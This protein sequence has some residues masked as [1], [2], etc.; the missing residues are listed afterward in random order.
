MDK[1]GFGSS[2][3]VSQACDGRG[4]RRRGRML[5][6]G[7]LRYVVLKYI[8]QQPRHGYDLI[9][10][11]QEQSGEVYS[12]S[13]GMIYPMLSMLEDLGY[14][15][16][17]NEGSKKLYYLTSQG[18]DFL[19]QNQELAQAI[20]NRLS[21][22][23]EQGAGRVRARLHALRDAVHERLP[24]AQGDPVLQERMATVLE[25]ALVEIQAL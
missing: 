20:E 16:V 13:P 15:S 4:G 8:G 24:L 10:I 22:L 21:A 9:K 11:L 14:V 12:P 3:A 6:Q 17:A 19:A 2:R 23:R 5:D 25:K 1:K 18:Q 7:M